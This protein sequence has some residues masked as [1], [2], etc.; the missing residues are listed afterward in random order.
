MKAPQ[1]E[2]VAPGMAYS[3]VAI[4]IVIASIASKEWLFRITHA[5]GQRAQSPSTIANAYHHRSDAMS[6]IAAA[7]GMGGGLFGFGM[8]DAA[9]AAVVGVMVM[10]MGFETVLEAADHN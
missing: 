4:G 3:G 2:A 6:S 8:I 10:K 1:I 9:A 5:V 7:L